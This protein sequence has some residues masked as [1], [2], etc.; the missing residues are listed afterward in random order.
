MLYPFLEQ[1]EKAMDLVATYIGNDRVSG[2]QDAA[3]A[4]APQRQSAAGART[5]V[6]TK[7]KGIILLPTFTK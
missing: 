1:V 4:A 6:S 3:A 2:S 5:T 7:A